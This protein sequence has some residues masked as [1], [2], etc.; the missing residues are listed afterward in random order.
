M[1]SQSLQVVLDAHQAVFQEGLGKM[2]GFKAKLH[3]NATANPCYTMCF[4]R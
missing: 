3:V 4:A 2:E 1:L